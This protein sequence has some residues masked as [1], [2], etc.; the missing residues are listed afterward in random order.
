MENLL[1]ML[2]LSIDINSLVKHIAQS[3]SL[4]MRN[5]WFDFNLKNEK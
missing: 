5:S 4:N 2:N 3:S 1:E